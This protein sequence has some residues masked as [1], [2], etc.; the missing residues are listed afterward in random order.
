MSVLGL[1]TKETEMINSALKRYGDTPLLSGL[2]EAQNYSLGAGGKRVR[3]LLCLLTARLFGGDD[4]AALPYAAALELIHTASLI[5]DDMPEIDDD[6]QRRG[7]PTNHKVFGEAKALLAADGLFIDAFSLVAENGA[8]DDT[9]N[10]LAVRTLAR[11]AGTT[12]LVGGEYI[13]VTCEGK[14]IDLD[15]LRAMH[16]KKTGALIV[17]SC[18]LGAI[19]AGVSEGDERFHDACEFARG[20]GLAFQIVD[21]ALDKVASAEAL[22][23][24]IGA[25]ERRGKATYLSFYS[26]D[27]AL[28]LAREI[29]EAAISHIEKYEGSA[30]LAALARE[31][32]LREK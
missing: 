6:D 2:T 1:L 20:I 21:D 22:G 27:A 13:D 17:A 16:S 15:T 4:T 14:K 8:L 7:I 10:L 24:P 26:P 29:T 25:D 30:L 28:A 31:L 19:A 11:A 32:A 9:A 3:P 5:H 18:A 23:K 12:G